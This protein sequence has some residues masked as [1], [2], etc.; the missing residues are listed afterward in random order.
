[1]ISPTSKKNVVVQVRLQFLKPK[2]LSKVPLFL[3]K[4]G[5]R[6]SDFFAASRFIFEG[7]L[8]PWLIYAGRVKS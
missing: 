3:V 5:M 1:M 7:E 8:F 6:R 2:L 4:C